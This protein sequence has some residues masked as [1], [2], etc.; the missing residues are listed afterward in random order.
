MALLAAGVGPGDEV[1]IPSLTFV[2][3]INVVRLLG[4]KP[5]LVDCT[6]YDDWNISPEGIAAAITPRTKAVLIVH[7]GGYACDMDAIISAD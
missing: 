3:D 7:Y 2:A 4:A 5:V 1:I 6:S